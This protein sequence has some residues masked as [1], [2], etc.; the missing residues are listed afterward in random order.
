MEMAGCRHCRL[1]G[2]MARQHRREVKSSVWDSTFTFTRRHV[3]LTSAPRRSSA[4]SNTPPS[5]LIMGDE[6]RLRMRMVTPP[7]GHQTLLRYNLQVQTFTSSNNANLLSN[8]SDTYLPT[9]VTSSKRHGLSSRRGL[10]TSG[11]L[12]N[13]RH[14]M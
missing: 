1:L 5:S 13:E 6:Y 9:V 10:E 11:T 14:E 12:Q 8:A 7:L 2:R 4:T 3:T